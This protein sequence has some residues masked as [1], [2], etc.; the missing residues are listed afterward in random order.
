ML[1][2]V[3]DEKCP[4]EYLSPYLWLED[5]LNR[6][7]T[8]ENYTFSTAGE[9]ANSCLVQAVREYLFFREKRDY[10]E[11]ITQNMA[12][13][14]ISPLK[15]SYERLK[16]LLITFKWKLEPLAT[17]CSKSPTTLKTVVSW[18]GYFSSPLGKGV[19]TYLEEAITNQSSQSLTLLETKRRF[20]MLQTLCKAKEYH[21]EI[22]PLF[23]IRPL[24]A[25]ISL[26]IKNLSDQ[27]IENRVDWIS[28]NQNT[29]I[30]ENYID[31]IEKNLY[32]MLNADEKELAH[33]FLIAIS[34]RDDQ[35]PINFRI[36]LYSH[37]RR[38]KQ[39]GEESTLTELNDSISIKLKEKI[40]KAIG[41]LHT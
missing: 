16:N 40:K 6:K 28:L 27:F 3:T 9:S 33:K 15:E 18:A 1:R 36:E 24:N 12:L 23:K 11:K 38:V 8:C 20:E 7:I 21:S 25:E 10:L 30:L 41:L 35:I 37:V 5:E 34:D 2:Q 39:A 32:D 4:F 26:L 14:K 31:H 17:L 19:A 29:I 22:S 13:T